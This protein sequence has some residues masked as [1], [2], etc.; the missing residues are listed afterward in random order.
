MDITQVSRFIMDS[1]AIVS[2]PSDQLYTDSGTPAPALGGVFL[3]VNV[4]TGYVAGDLDTPSACWMIINLLQLYDATKD[5]VALDR[6][7]MIGDYLVGIIIDVSFYGSIMKVMPNRRTYSG[8]S[9]SN[10][11]ST[12]HVRTQYHALWAFMRL[13]Q[14]TG[15]VGYRTAALYML[16][17]VGNVYN[18]IKAR[19]TTQAEISTWM[20]GAVYNTINWIGTYDGSG[21]PNVTFSW[22]VFALSTVDV[23]AAGVWY[24]VSI[25]GNDAQTDWEGTSFYPQSIS[26]DYATFIAYAYQNKSIL[27]AS[28]GLMYH[29]LQYEDSDTKVSGRYEP[30]PKNW[31]WI[32]N[33]WGDVWWVGDLELWTI[34][35]LISMGLSQLAETLLFRLYSL[36]VP[37]MRDVVFYDRLNFDGTPLSDDKS[38]SIAYTGLFLKIAYSLGIT[39]FYDPCVE[40]LLK[41]QISS[42]D[43]NQDGGYPW[44]IGS[45]ANI[46][47]KTVGEILRVLFDMTRTINTRPQKPP[48][49]V[50][51][52][53]TAKAT[54][55]AENY[56][57]AVLVNA[58]DVHIPCEVNGSYTL[59]FNL[60]GNDENISYISEENFIKSPGG[61][62]FAIKSVEKNKEPGKNTVC[63]QCEHV[64]FLAID[65]YIEEIELDTLTPLAAMTNV[66][67][68]SGCEHTLSAIVPTATFDYVWKQDTNPVEMTQEVVKQV[69]GELDP[70]NFK[71]RLLDRL[72]SNNGVQIRYRKNLKGIKRTE[73]TKSLVTRLI[74]LGADN[75]TIEDVN[76]GKK[77]IDSAYINN[78]RRPKVK[79]VT[80]SEIEDD[81]ELLT[82]AQEYLATVEIPEVA[83]EVDLIELKNLVEY[84]SDETIDE[85]DTVTIIDEDWGISIQ[86]RVMKY[87][88]YPY[89][90]YK[91]KA[92]L[93]NFVPDTHHLFAEFNQVAKSVLSGR[94]DIT[95]K[96]GEQVV[97]QDGIDLS[98]V[99]GAG[100][101]SGG[102]ITT[103]NSARTV[104]AHSL[105]VAY[106]SG[107]ATI[108][109]SSTTGFPAFG[110]AH[111]T[112]SEGINNNGSFTYTGLDATHFT[113]VTITS[114]NIANILASSHI[115][116]WPVAT[117]DVS[118]SACRA[119]NS[120]KQLLRLPVKTWTSLNVTT[121][122][123]D[124][125]GSEYRPIW[126][127]DSGVIE[128]GASGTGGGSYDP[129]EPNYY[130]TPYV[131]AVK[132]GYLIIGYNKTEPNGLINSNKNFDS[133]GIPVF[134]TIIKHD[135]RY[136]QEVVLRNDGGAAANLTSYVTEVKSIAM[137]ANS[138][139]TVY[140]PLGTGKKQGNVS[141]TANASKTAADNL[142]QGAS[143]VVGRK[144]AAGTESGVLV[145]WGI[146]VD[147][148]GNATHVDQKRNDTG[149]DYLIPPAALNATYA[150]IYDMDLMPY[151]S[152]AKQIA[153]KVQFYNPTANTESLNLRFNIS[154]S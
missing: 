55:I 107:A 85:G 114:G 110:T 152:D 28:T 62:L 123:E 122:P 43:T 10:V 3:N 136:R 18:N 30:R 101:I 66:W 72:G 98:Q 11:Y 1:K 74:P 133:N 47:V 90:D 77:Y 76:G 87:D 92:T 99:V 106:N 42:T 109:V 27:M 86:A 144:A 60:P 113:G 59:C 97:N 147:S 125:D 94:V 131:H 124:Y 65:E 78:Y 45:L 141:I 105:F 48:L 41:F 14:E 44:D 135:L 81:T 15:T 68:I 34:Y 73:N 63:V 130:G 88:P 13:Y 20:A 9:W 79:V 25:I 19:A 91:S 24:W 22:Q 37:A 139:Q 102:I 5:Q 108:Q 12:I 148:T 127:N 58:T 39:R 53:L 117:I 67:N 4:N 38:I 51:D 142:V 46:E 151:P 96:F 143:F 61:Q 104:A 154:A 7:K 23:M 137:A 120:L 82:K 17:T 71:V 49:R 57:D 138:Y 84:G 40:A 50:Y 80:W 115:Y 121:N 64:Y 70:D 6:A 145:V 56:G 36:R 31:D 134:T 26:T 126:I 8:G 83:Y 132:I 100:I 21:R 118:V 150:Y 149:F 29:F 33:I 153:L 16:R 103:A 54:L 93:A 112:Y 129:A 116:T 111:F 32:N 75:L 119:V 52:K 140:I 95:N 2:N 89:E 128:M 146:Y 69:G 35:G